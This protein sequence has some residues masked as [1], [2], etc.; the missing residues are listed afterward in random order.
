MSAALNGSQPQLGSDW[1]GLSPH[2]IA[3]FYA[4]KPADSDGTRYERDANQPVVLAPITDGNVE[5]TVSWQSAFE[6]IGPDQKLGTLSAMLQSG[7][8]T[9]LLEALKERFS[10]FAGV[11]GSIERIAKDMEGR[12]SFTKL[13]STQVFNGMP[14]LKIAVT[15]HFRAWSD[16]RREVQAPMN[17]LMDWALPRKLADDVPASAVRNM[18]MNPWQSVRPTV[19]AMKYAGMLF[20]PIVIESI[21]Y[22]LTGPRDRAGNLSHASITL[23]LASLTAL[24]SADWADVVA[25]KQMRTR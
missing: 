13:N 10:G 16:A 21:P 25:G 24:D 12:S 1:G 4:L 9:S 20:S 14:P 2:L 22:P 7:G 15:A 19:I 23:S 17:K 5:T 18:S 6:N 11:V 8:F 3:T